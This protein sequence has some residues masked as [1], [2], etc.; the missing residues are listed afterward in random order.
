MRTCF[1][2]PTFSFLT[3]LQPQQGEDNNYRKWPAEFD[4]SLNAK[5][6]HLPLT[7]ALRGTQL[8]SALL[9]HPAFEKKTGPGGKK[10]LDDI[11]R[12]NNART[13]KLF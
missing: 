12:E 8:F 1:F 9:D 10:T 13:S 7:N 5:K 3:L 4:Y 2:F 6:G 11:A